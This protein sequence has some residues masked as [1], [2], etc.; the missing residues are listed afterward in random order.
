MLNGLWGQHFYSSRTKTVTSSGGS[1][2][3]T[4]FEQFVIQPIWDAY[5]SVM[6]GDID[7][8]TKVVQ[9]LKL[10]VAAKDIH[11]KDRRIALQSIMS[12]WVCSLYLIL[13][14]I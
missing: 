11:H 8:A 13:T 6:S 5:S 1:G 14:R 10:N 7:A 4:M 9:R 12:A 3:S 2:R